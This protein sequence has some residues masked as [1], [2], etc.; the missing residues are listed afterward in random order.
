MLY[1]VDDTTEKKTTLTSYPQERCPEEYESR[2]YEAKPLARGG[3]LFC[4]LPHTAS[5]RRH[6]C[7]YKSTDRW[8]LLVDCWGHV[9]LHH[10][11]PSRYA[12]L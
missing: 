10:H 6:V 8:D 4:F 5:S 3:Q 9:S 7:N 11:K 2:M 1:A 12:R